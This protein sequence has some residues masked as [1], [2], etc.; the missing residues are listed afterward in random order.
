MAPVTVW[1]FITKRSPVTGNAACRVPVGTG[2]RRF[3]TDPA[4]VTCKKCLKRSKLVRITRYTAT[5]TL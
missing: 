2:A 4:Q 1:H 5:P 3:T